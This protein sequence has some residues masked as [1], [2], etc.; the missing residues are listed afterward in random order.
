MSRPTSPSRVLETLWNRISS[1][2][3]EVLTLPEEAGS[4][5]PRV[6]RRLSWRSSLL[7][8]VIN[9]VYVNP[10]SSPDGNREFVEIR[11]T[12]NNEALTDLWLLQ[13][14]GDGTA[15]G[16]VD[17]AINL[18]SLSTGSNGLLLL[19][20]SYGTTNPWPRRPKPGTTV[21]NGP[22]ADNLENGT[23]TFLLVTGFT[24]AVTNDL[25]T[26][27]D[28]TFDFTPWTGIVDSVG[29]TDGGA[30][31]RV[32]SAAALVQNG[33]NTRCGDSHRREQHGEFRRSLVCVGHPRPD[34]GWRIGPG[35]R[36]GPRWRRIPRGRS[37]Y[38]R[39][40]QLLGH[41]AGCHDHS[42][43]RNDRCFR[44]RYHRHLH[45]EA[46]HRSCRKRR[47]HRH[48]K[49]PITGQHRWSE[50]LQFG[51]PDLLGY[52]GSDRHRPRH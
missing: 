14:E 3:G 27:N 9:E 50:L 28:G 17:T 37:H 24:G 34:C 1:A 48:C 36:P 18:G 16:V 51:H 33:G 44:S 38:S 22:V 52:D 30:G 20:A 40:R 31:D 47:D 45:T 6:G 39:G 42:V 4:P 8:A 13:I 12:T 41:R 11:T 23:V 43:R 2:I 15:A 25:D 7:A 26:N 19:G 5:L 49:Q 46:R 32:Y 35:L 29:W 10:T 21:A